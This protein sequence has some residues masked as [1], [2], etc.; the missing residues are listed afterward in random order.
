MVLTQ[1]C[2]QELK[3]CQRLAQQD[4]V[5]PELWSKCLVRLCYGLWFTCLPA[6]TKTCHSKVRALRTAYDLLRT[7][8]TKNLQPP[9]EV[10]LRS[11]LDLSKCQYV[12]IFYT[13]PDFWFKNGSVF[14]K[15]LFC[16]CGIVVSYNL[17]SKYD[18]FYLNNSWVM[19]NE[20]FVLVH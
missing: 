2:C 8:T 18:F 11:E 4:S 14:T 5:V 12:F 6:Y 16:C 1:C 19:V 3:S 9:D 13:L 20:N 7:M 10:S 17:Q 15:P